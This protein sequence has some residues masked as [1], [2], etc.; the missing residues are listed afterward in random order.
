M[1]ASELKP[2]LRGIYTI[3]VTPFREDYELDIDG[4]KRNLDFLLDGSGVHGIVIGGSLGEFSSMSMEE[5]KLLIKTAVEHVAG[6]LPVIATTAHSNT[7]EALEL[8]KY[9][10]SIGAD[11]VMITA[12]YYAHRPEEGIY[13]HFETIASQTEIGI[14]LY[15]TS[16]AGI[17][18]T[19]KFI[20]RL[21]EIDHIAGIKQG[22]RNI[23]EHD[24]TVQLVGDKIS[25]LSGSEE[26]M[27]PCFAL[28]EV[29]TSSTC[30]SFMPQFMV[31]CYEAAQ[32]GDYTEAKRVFD[33]WAEFRHFARANGQP[34]TAKAAMN[35]MGMAA[36]PVRLPMVDL[37]AEKKEELRK[38]LQKMGL[39]K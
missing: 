30:S 38:I 16:R 7:R 20:A 5:R 32:R 35:M 25:I 23:I 14:L 4:V 3:F 21:C 29:G 26:M 17:N 9:A 27:L 31:P 19:P 24:E 34:A 37:N 10:E 8:T 15:N 18:L 12:P 6:R 22:T 11:G 36:G 39:L 13:R 33:S 28:G 2:K 1:K